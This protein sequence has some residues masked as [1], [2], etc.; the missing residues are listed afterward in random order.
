MK[1]TASLIVAA[2]FATP[3]AFTAHA[4]TAPGFSAEQLGG[5][6]FNLNKALESGYVMLHFWDTCCP[7]CRE[8]LPAVEKV[9][10]SGCDS[11]TIIG[12]STDSPKTQSKIKPFL[13]SNSYTFSVL[14]DPN[15]EIR[16]LFGGTENPLTIL[17]SPSG[18]VLMRRMGTAPDEET[19]LLKE[20]LSQLNRESQLNSPEQESH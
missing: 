11:L 10:R 9:K 8:A 4:E 14:L 5:G 13:K 16:K 18:E 17:I 1:I 2:I 19:V 12:I 7:G 6:K 3:L 20:I 15:L